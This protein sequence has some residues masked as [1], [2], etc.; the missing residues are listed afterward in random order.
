[1]EVEDG[2]EPE[3]W[4]LAVSQVKNHEE[5]SKVGGGVVLSWKWMS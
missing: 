1:M 2:H 3:F 4:G 5:V